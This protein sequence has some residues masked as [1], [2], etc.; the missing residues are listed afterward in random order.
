MIV[1]QFVDLLRRGGAIAAPGVQDALTA[2]IAA[3]A[4]AQ[5][6]YLGGNA[7]ALGLGKGQP[8]LTLTETAALTTRVTRAIDVPLLVDAGAGFGAG[9]HLRLAVRELEAAG[10]AAIHLDDQPYPKLA[11]YHR[12]QGSLVPADEMAARLRIARAARHDM[13]VIARTDALRVTKS[14]D[15]TIR[16]AKCY[17]EAGADALI[18]LDLDP[19]QAPIVHDALPDFPLLWIGG[20]VPPVPSRDEL[21][22][23]GFAMALYPFSGVAITITALT[24]LW[25]G[26]AE[27]GR[28]AVS[29]D[30]LARARSET[31]ALVDMAASWAVEDQA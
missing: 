7:M 25:A 13:L 24:N 2:L 19:A 29:G 16:R 15:E 11:D 3:R 14:L 9:S 12:G 10:A 30:L 23:A 27:T 26:L 1:A 5:A 8:F 17:G 18:V 31:L 20:V 28:P 6:L 21:S 4:G 22:A